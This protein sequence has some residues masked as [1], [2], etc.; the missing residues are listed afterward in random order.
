MTITMMKKKNIL[1]SITFAILIIATL[2]T[3]TYSNPITISTN[4]VQ[5]N[6][7]SA[8]ISDVLN[9]DGGDGNTSTTTTAAPTPSNDTDL[10]KIHHD[11]CAEVKQNCQL[12]NGDT[13]LINY[14]YIHYCIFGGIPAISY[15]VIC[16]W[17]LLVLVML[18]TT[19]DNYFVI[20]LETLSAKLKL[21]PSTAGITL[22][23]LGNSAPDTFTDIASV[24]GGSYPL[25]LNELIGASMFLTTIVFAAVILVSTKKKVKAMKSAGEL[26]FSAFDAEDN[27][28]YQICQVDKSSFLRDVLVFFGALVLILFYTITDKKFTMFESLSVILIYVLYVFGVVVTTSSWFKKR[29][30]KR[31]EKAYRDIMSNAAN[32]N[33]IDSKSNI[34]NNKLNEHML[35]PSLLE[36]EEARLRIKSYTEGDD[37]EDSFEDDFGEQELSNEIVGIDW[38]ADASIIDKVIFIFEFPFV[39]LRWISIPN[40]DKNWD[41]RRRYLAALAPMGAVCVIFLDF[42]S[43][44]TGGTPYDGF[45]YPLNSDST[46]PM[47]VVFLIPALIL[48]LIIFFSTDNETLP[49][50]YMLLVSLAFVSTVAWLDLIGNEVVALLQVLGHIT[51]ITNTAMGINILGIT[52]LSWANSI[53]DFVAD[54]AVA[55]AGSPRM[56]IS[57]VFGS[58]L[59]TACL[60]LGLAT[61]ITES[62]RSDHAIDTDVSS[63]IDHIR[64]SFGFLAAS[65]F[66]SLVVV[67][68]NQ[69]TVPRAYAYYLIVLYLAFMGVKIH[70]FL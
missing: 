28:E 48:G 1:F 16:I 66:S 13:F 22:L 46:L 65:L 62:T 38:D 41:W 20:Q 34:S 45:T 19:A 42:S 32:I 25:A 51:G 10:C 21:S 3:S 36:E 12:G 11:T 56:G 24:E 27:V 18:S 63:T 58:P 69:F 7:A 61:L 68:Y 49:S 26:A 52:V 53:G 44:W 8:L 6:D 23:A 33:D 2:T 59:L 15:I 55:K 50:W 43:N 47:I 70:S 30:F 29:F 64:V 57:S 35:V 67:S 4:I 60:G 39:L 54:T 9:G 5:N 37:D 40:G 31:N 14:Y 17:F